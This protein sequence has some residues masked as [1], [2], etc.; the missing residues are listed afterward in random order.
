MLTLA[1]Q[2]VISGY[3]VYAAVGAGLL[4]AVAAV[5]VARQYKRCPSDKIL[6]LYGRVGKDKSS[7][8]LYGGGAFVV[9]MV[10]DYAYLSLEPIVVDVPLQGT[11]TRDG[12]R[13]N[14]P[15]TFTVAISTDPVLMNNAAERL[16]NMPT[17]VI[18]DQAQDIILGQLRLT[19]AELTIKEISENRDKFMEMIN[20]NVGEELNK[21]GLRL[22]NVSV[23]DLTDE[24]GYFVGMGRRA[25]ADAVRAYLSL[26]PHKVSVDGARVRTKDGVTLDVGGR[27]AFAVQYGAA[28]D[29]S[30]V[31]QLLNL[32]EDEQKE[33]ARVVFI[34]QVQLLAEALT[35]G[36]IEA[37][38]ERMTTLTRKLAGGEFHRR[39]LELMSVDVRVAGRRLS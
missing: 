21:L 28:T 12:V 14:V 8:C 16:L 11:P 15:S 31:Q 29:E 38:P 37:D 26:N 4:I 2:P 3:F 13:L 32:P 19:V 9:P 39:G 33:R 10:Q 22:I 36:E 27:F 5:V 1:S 20:Q 24:S 35:A 18:R 7:R 23:R 30:A 17:Q 6:V 34:E 25:A